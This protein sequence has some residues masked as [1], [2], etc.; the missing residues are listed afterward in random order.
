[1][2]FIYGSDADK[3]VVQSS[4]WGREVGI[5]Y[6]YYENTGLIQKLGYV[7]NDNPVAEPL[8]VLNGIVDDIGIDGDGYLYVL[9]TEKLHL[10]LIWLQQ[11]LKSALPTSHHIMTPPLAGKESKSP[12]I[13]MAR[14]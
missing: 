11:S 6:E 12:P 10:T 7:S 1:M 5:A 14:R 2:D 8:G 9:R 4:W 13:L 3:F